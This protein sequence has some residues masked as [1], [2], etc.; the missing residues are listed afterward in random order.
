MYAV[1]RYWAGRKLAVSSLAVCLVQAI[2]FVAA[3]CFVRMQSIEPP[4]PLMTLL[5]IMYLSGTPAAI[6]LALGGIVRDV[7]RGAA[8]LAALVC[9]L[10][11]TL[12]PLV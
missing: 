5:G 9:G 2:I 7:H 8:L 12:Q 10:F 4:L 11:C 3:I 6:L 1:H